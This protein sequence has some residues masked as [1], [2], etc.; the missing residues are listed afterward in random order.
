MII[1][2]PGTRVWIIYLL[3]SISGLF[4]PLFRSTLVCLHLTFG[5]ISVDEWSSDSSGV[6]V[7]LNYLHVCIYSMFAFEVFL[8][9]YR[10]SMVIFRPLH[11]FVGMNCFDVVEKQ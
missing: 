5:Y 4:I 9:G 1:F 3:V 11:G 2:L 8:S 10:P 7:F 6:I